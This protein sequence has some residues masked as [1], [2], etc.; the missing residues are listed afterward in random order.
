MKYATSS[1]VRIAYD[2]WGG[3][4]PALLFLPGWCAS[5]IVFRRLI[6]LLSG[7]ARVLS[8]DWRSHGDS[9]AAPGDFGFDALVEDALAVIEAAGVRS[10]VPVS[11]AHAGWVSIALRRRL[12]A[13]I[14]KAVLLEWIITEP[15]ESF[16]DLLDGMQSPTGC[17]E[18]LE[19]IF[20][21]WLEGSNDPELVH[22]VRKVMGAHGFEMWARSAR[23]IEQ[24]YASA[25]SPLKALA[26][27]HPPMP[28]LHL[29]AQPDA[30]R[31]MSAQQDFA[32]GHPW[33]SVR[34]LAAARSHFPMFEAPSEIAD[35]IDGFLAG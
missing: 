1:G 16:L 27:I 19:T 4:E 15:P 5:R 17:A 33:F 21:I 18:I 24:A 35:A 34:K 7:H 2:D 30:P 22:F 20:G 23:S 9:D 11:L 10:L 12:G 28:V 31:Y 25:G 29:Y 3:R 32:A 8:L 13:R 6:A 14:A 26:A